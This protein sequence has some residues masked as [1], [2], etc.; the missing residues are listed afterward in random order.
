MPNQVISVLN[1][2]SRI[3]SGKTL[4]SQD[5]KSPVIIESPEI[6]LPITA[7]Q[8]LAKVGFLKEDEFAD[9]GLKL[10][11][12]SQQ[13]AQRLKKL[14]FAVFDDIPRKVVPKFPERTTSEPSRIPM[15][16]PNP[17]GLRPVDPVQMT[18]VDKVREKYGLTGKGVTVAVIDSGIENPTVSLKGWL[19][20]LDDSK[21]PIDP[22]GH[23]THVSSDI[24]KMAPDA[25]IIGIRVTNRDG[26][27]LTSDIMKGIQWAISH[28]D[29]YG[30]KLMNLSLGE[31]STSLFIPSPLNAAVDKAVKAGITVVCAAGNS[32]PKPGSIMVPAEEQDVI[33]VGSVLD[34]NTISDF[35]SR[36]PNYLGK[37]RPDLLAPG[38][39]IVS[40]TPPGSE[41]A[42]EA[43]AQEK[44]RPL[45]Q[46]QVLELLNEK[47]GLIKSL[48]LPKDIMT[49][50]KAEIERLVKSSL[51][52]H[53][54]E[55]GMVGAP[56]TSFS[57]PE[58]TGIA[59]LL[60]EAESA[61][62]PG[63]LKQ[64][65]MESAREIPGDYSHNDQGAGLVDAQ[66]AVK[67]LL[68]RTSKTRKN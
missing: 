65:L 67:L 36:G 54:P 45:S 18:G 53:H 30:I 58:V 4:R 40:Y 21:T 41:M 3:K 10:G 22:S 24:L 15:L 35:S 38:E 20:Y 7:D 13:N 44:I 56:G 52:L 8:L 2:N 5:R 31:P 63:E 48:E 66:R 55:T 16:D 25:E 42:V 61:L 26:I 62:S 11:R 32:G 28:K 57:A 29:E 9:L 23:G 47:P 46:D 37:I 51:N 6:M 64:L 33:A 1:P 50:P 19:D 60:L 39:D 27:A 12:I 49:R 34:P 14:G 43:R 17:W 59:A 68:S